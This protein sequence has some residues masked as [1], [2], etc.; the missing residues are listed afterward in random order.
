MIESVILSVAIDVKGCVNIVQHR[1]FRT[2]FGGSDQPKQLYVPDFR[3]WDNYYK[4]KKEQE[5]PC[6]SGTGSKVKINLVSPVSE[7]VSQAESV[8]KSENSNTG[9]KK[10]S[11]KTKTSS[12]KKQ[13]IK[14]KNKTKPSFDRRKL[15][16]IF[17]KRKK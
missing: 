5:K 8:M 15:N 10:K 16:D 11:T 6:A 14:K 9:K 7:T 17:S 1:C 4:V 13:G 2:M 12:V 3:V